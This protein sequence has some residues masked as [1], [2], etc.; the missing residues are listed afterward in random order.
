[1]KPAQLELGL[2]LSDAP[3]G[4]ELTVFSFGGGQ[5]S[6][7]ILYLLVY[8]PAFRKK[9]A[10]GKLLVVMSDTGDEHPGTYRAVVYAKEFCQ[11]HHIEFHFITSDRGF[12]PR[13]WQSL[14]A[15]YDKNHTIGSVAFDQTCTDNL[16]VKVVD[17][18]TE[19]WIKEHYGITGNKKKAYWKFTGRYGKVRLL[20][21][22]AAGEEHR[23]KSE[24]EK[25]YDAVWKQNCVERVYPLFELGIDRKGAQDLIKRLGEYLPPPSNCMKCFYMSEQELLWL[26]RFHRDVF[27]RWVF[28][29]R[30]KIN[31]SRAKGVPDKKNMGVFGRITIIGKLRIATEKYGHWTDEQLNDYK[32]SHGHCVKSKY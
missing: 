29:E 27:W 19:W 8:D 25:E 17:N 26:Y 18:F 24:K 13:T 15:Q 23:T 5:D 9:Y 14:D 4:G 3:A 21:G 31:K 32:M 6:F 22:F 7:A 2:Q 10:P 28:Q 20:L 1:M 16:K 12:H 30:R 11:K